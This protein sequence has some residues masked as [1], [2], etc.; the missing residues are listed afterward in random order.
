MVP[1]KI[2]QIAALNFMEAYPGNT[3]LNRVISKNQPRQTTNPRRVTKK[4]T[5]KKYLSLTGA[6]FFYLR[7]IYA[8]YG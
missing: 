4:L 3:D 8:T 1:A 6:I 5:V 2:K 7:A